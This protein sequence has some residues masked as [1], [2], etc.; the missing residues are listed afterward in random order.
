M[1]NINFYQ[2]NYS[3]GLELYKKA[4]SIGALGD[5]WNYALLANLAGAYHYT[6]N[7]ETAK[8]YTSEFR[9]N[10]AQKVSKK[11]NSNVIVTKGSEG[12]TAFLKDGEQTIHYTKDENK[13]FV[14]SIGA[15]DTFFAGFI[16]GVIYNKDTLLLNRSNPLLLLLVS[17]LSGIALSGGK[18][19]NINIKKRC[20]NLKC[21]TTPL[22]VNLSSNEKYEYSWPVTLYS[23]TLNGK[24]IYC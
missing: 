19:I 18:V 13:N 20:K 6:G 23:P 8:K 12:F 4:E 17:L 24:R 22:K 10:I 16:A 14:D 11:I 2:G 7:Y 3:Q 15:G 1:G 5:W 9:N 21:P